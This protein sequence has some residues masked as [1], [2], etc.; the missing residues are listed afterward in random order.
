MFDLV[1]SGGDSF[2]FGAELT[3]NNSVDPNP[4]SWANLVAQRIGKRHINVARSGRSNSYITRQVLAEIRQA[5]DQATAPEK[6]F[7]QVMWTFT[8]RNEF[9]VGIDLPEYDSPWLALTP[10]S[11]CD[12][13]ESEWFKKVD[14]SLSTWKS[15]YDNLKLSYRR[16]QQL[17]ITDFAE[18]YQKLVQSSPVNDSYTSIKEIVLLQN[19]LLLHKIPYVFTYV[20]QR[21][22]YGL[23]SDACQNR[24]LDSARS[25]V[26]HNSWFRFP[27]DWQTHVGFDD[28]AKQNNYEYATS[29]PLETAHADAAELIYN[30]LA[31]NGYT[32]DK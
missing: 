31:K 22:I 14:R 21:V 13:T 19:I 8:N 3:A 4:N 20:N 5:L 32:D 6:I 18:K 9:A 2:T 16:K 7:V 25:F 30:Y 29:H 24:Y 26:D 12:E 17:G 11:H 27:G 1:I 28:W 10:Y 23:F 15:V